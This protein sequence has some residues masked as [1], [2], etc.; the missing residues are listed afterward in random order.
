MTVDEA[1]KARGYEVYD[2]ALPQPWV[3]WQRKRGYEVVRHFVWCYD[4]EKI[5]GE[6]APIT[7]EG[8][9]MLPKV[10]QFDPVM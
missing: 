6:P 9:R 7:T 8:D 2:C 4:K 10:L 3:D 1:A 5:F